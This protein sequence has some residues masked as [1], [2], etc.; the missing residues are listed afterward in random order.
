MKKLPVRKPEAWE[1][2]DHGECAM[3]YDKSEA[4]EYIAALESRLAEVEKERD[5]AKLGWAETQRRLDVARDDRERLKKERD[6]LKVSEERG[7]QDY[8]ELRNIA[9][10][11]LAKLVRLVGLVEEAVGRPENE[12]TPTDLV[13]NVDALIRLVALAADY[14]RVQS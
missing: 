10:R 4:D 2:I 8:L 3:V 13:L 14:R 6:D 5:D 9:D 7:V 12:L 1:A 11:Y